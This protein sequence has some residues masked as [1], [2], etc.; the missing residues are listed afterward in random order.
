MLR[1][2]MVTQCGGKELNGVLLAG[3]TNS[4]DNDSLSSVVI[5][6]KIFT[7]K[8]FLKRVFCISLSFNIVC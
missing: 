4:D 2:I 7:A 8:S 3:T 5:F 1:D 6:I